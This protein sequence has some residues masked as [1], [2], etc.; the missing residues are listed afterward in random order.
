MN[1][2]AQTEATHLTEHFRRHNFGR[3]DLEATV[4]DPTAY[5]SPRQSPWQVGSFFPMRS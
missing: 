3:I 4:G 5:T 1:G 2:H